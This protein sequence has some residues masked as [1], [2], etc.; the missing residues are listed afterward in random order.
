MIRVTPSE[1]F[2]DDPDARYLR[3]SP[4]PLAEPE[5]IP[6]RWLA[7]VLLALIVLSCSACSAADAAQEPSASA[8][9]LKRAAASA[10]L[11]PGMHAQW[12]DAQ[13]VACIPEK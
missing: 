5:R 4:G 6:G 9:D 13:T 10:W 7:A 3:E 12:L 2:C 8:A 11:C 1:P